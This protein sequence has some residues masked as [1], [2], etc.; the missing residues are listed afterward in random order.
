MHLS[1][2]SLEAKSLLFL[3]CVVLDKSRLDH[4]SQQNSN[5]SCLRSNRF[6][7]FFLC[8]CLLTCFSNVKVTFKLK[9]WRLFQCIISLVK[10][11]T[12]WYLLKT[13]WFLY[14]SF[15]PPTLF[16]CLYETSMIFHTYESWNNLTRN[17]LKRFL[18]C[19]SSSSMWPYSFWVLILSVLCSCYSKAVAVHVLV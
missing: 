14:K 15:Q 11:T 3:V 19:D 2:L 18:S 6:V 9:F 1:P 17:L 13:H 5:L 7:V 12:H 16:L 8:A 10:G 4:P